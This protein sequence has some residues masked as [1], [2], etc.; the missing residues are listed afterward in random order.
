MDVCGISKQETTSTLKQEILR[1]HPMLFTHINHPTQSLQTT[2]SSPL[3]STGHSSEVGKKSFYYRSPFCQMPIVNNTSQLESVDE[4]KLE[5]PSIAECTHPS[6]FIDPESGICECGTVVR[7][8][9][10][11]DVS[12]LGIHHHIFVGSGVRR[13]DKLNQAPCVDFS[14]MQDSSSLTIP[15]SQSM[16]NSVAKRR[17]Y[18]S[19]TVPVISRSR[20][21]K[22]S[23]SND[24]SKNLNDE[25]HVKTFRV[26]R[27]PKVVPR[28]VNSLASPS[29][30]PIRSRGR[31]RKI[32]KNAENES[33]PPTVPEFIQI[34]K[35]TRRSSS[36][37]NIVDQLESCE[38]K[39]LEFDT[40]Q[41]LLVSISMRSK[42][43]EYQVE[44]HFKTCFEEVMILSST[45]TSIYNGD[46]L[47]PQ[48]T[49]SKMSPIELAERILKK[50]ISF[51]IKTHNNNFKN[52]L[53]I[54][55]LSV[56]LY[57]SHLAHLEP[58]TEISAMET[59]I[60]ECPKKIQ[61]LI[62]NRIGEISE[63]WRIIHKS[64]E[65]AIELFTLIN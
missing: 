24:P 25:E 29:V 54:L 30:C 14:E 17:R 22:T 46:C 27:P 8:C 11:R 7:V 34:I 26:G 65:L 62:S 47:C 33:A 20:S 63:S 23:I 36:E 38:F 55:V 32:I 4:D 2:S 5:I 13:K 49:P 51:F 21:I 61:R 53:L 60:R 45:G 50:N 3:M 19:M 59:I 35:K 58:S 64:R 28:L 40:K 57:I 18:R 39:H 16:I 37:L 12:G 44:K 52:S 42:F 31:P 10:V 9:M 6:H 56:H 1:Q 48:I 15:T 43:K 41:F